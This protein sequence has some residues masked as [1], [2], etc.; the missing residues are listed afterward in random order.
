MK[1]LLSSSYHISDYCG[2]NEQYFHQLAVSLNKLGH[3]VIYLTG[4]AQ[5]ISSFP[6]KI[7]SLPLPHFF[8]KPLPSLTWH[9]YLK[10]FKPD[11]FHASGSGFPLIF[12]AFT[13]KKNH[14]IPTF[15]TYQGSTNPSNLLLK[16]PAKLEQYLIPKAFDALITTTP[17]YQK[18]LKNKWPK[19]HISFIPMM[20]SP[21][22]EKKLP[23]K[24]DARK[25]VN[26]PNDKKIVLFTGKLSSHQYYKG[27][28]VLIEAAAK[29]PDD[30]LIVIVGEGD[31]KNYYQEMVDSLN[32]NKKIL[33]AGFVTNEK[34]PF[35]Y[36]SADV[37]V[38]PSTSDSEGF[39]LVLIEAMACKTPTITTTAIGSASWFKKQKVTT[40]VPVK[41]AQA[42][43]AAI[44]E[45]VNNRP[46]ELIK[47]A[48]VFSQ[49]FN[50]DK[51]AKNTIDFYNSFI[52]KNNEK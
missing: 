43:T 25:Q 17:Y 16:A 2:G 42:L 45:N 40:L 21:H 9:K 24:Q 52:T 19:K 15:L 14:K 48:F 5:K 35:F 1:I 27:V 38:L 22:L 51:M 11:V 34:I 37:F 46:N 20:L 3:E 23:S 8:G 50:A 29:L 44:I 30:Y 10:N 12:S 36:R 7:I 28:D 6:Y 41:N 18:K 32:L 26:L 33:F 39:G 13:L 31:K 47:Q 49:N 4:K